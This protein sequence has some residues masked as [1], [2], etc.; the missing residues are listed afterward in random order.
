MFF[1]LL[2]GELNPL[3][4]WIGAIAILCVILIITLL[5]DNKKFVFDAKCLATAGICTA[6]SLVLSLIKVF[7]LPQGGSVTIA[8]LLPLFLFSYIY[9]ARKGVLV[10]LILGLLNFACDPWFVHPGQFLLDYILA[11]SAI[12]IS[13][14]FGKY[15]FFTK[16][17][18]LGFIFGAIIS[19]LIRYIS[20]TISGIFAFSIYATSDVILYSLGYN[21]FVWIDS[22]ISIVLGLA[23]VSSKTIMNNFTRK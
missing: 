23:I 10:G 22:A 13:G 7:T 8:S 19:T 9:G 4:L 11:F 12:G 3:A 15:D 5:G 21:A 20:H 2:D 14:M 18:Q 6:L 16:H 17:I 1:N